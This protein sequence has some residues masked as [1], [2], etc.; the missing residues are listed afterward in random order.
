MKFKNNS[1]INIKC[2]G[3]TITSS[4]TPT[5]TNKDLKLKKLNIIDNDVK[6][7]SNIIT[8]SKEN[9]KKNTFNFCGCLVRKVP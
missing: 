6:I 5:T 2:L 9:K 1:N 8:E 3:N 7:I 4:K